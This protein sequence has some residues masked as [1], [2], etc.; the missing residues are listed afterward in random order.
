MIDLDTTW[1]GE[2][3]PYERYKLFN[4]ILDI[5]PANILEIGAG[6]GGSTRS[7]AE[8]I[9]KLGIP[10]IIY[11]CDLECGLANPFLKA[12]PFVAF[13]KISSDILIQ[14]LIRSEVNIDFILF[15]G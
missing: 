2:M 5:K 11:T 9:K 7:M 12:F 15:D 3:L 10:S 8:A 14:D 13:H 4:W 6:G 1:Q